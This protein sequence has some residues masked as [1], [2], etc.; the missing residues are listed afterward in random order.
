MGN[1]AV[2]CKDSDDVQKKLKNI[3]RRQARATP[4]EKEDGYLE[5][6]AKESSEC[7][8]LNKA[9]RRVNCAG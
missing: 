4:S 8:V 2:Q 7:T 6:P 3:D 5:E 1:K 9:N